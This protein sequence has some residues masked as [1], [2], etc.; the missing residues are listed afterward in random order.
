MTYSTLNH[1]YQDIKILGIGNLIRQDEGIGI[2][3]LQAL[4][5]NLPDGIETLDGGTGGLLLLDY[6]EQARKLIVLDAAETGKEPG[7]TVLWRNDEVP[8]F[9][10][11]KMSVHQVGFAEVLSLAKFRGKYP[12]EIAVVGIQPQTLDWGL[13]LSEPVQKALPEA[14]NLVIALLEEWG[15]SY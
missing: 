1:S 4:E 14:L 5:H 10:A 9:M 2:H 8:Y 7:S 13:D 6:V 3:L 15:V 11:S 12:Q